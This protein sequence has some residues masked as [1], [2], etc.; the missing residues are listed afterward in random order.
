MYLLMCF[1]FS[2]RRR[3]TR[4]P[5]D[6]SSD[7]CSSDL[8]DDAAGLA[9]AQR[10]GNAVVDDLSLTTPTTFSGDPTTREKLWHVRKGQIGRA[11]CRERVQ[12]S[13]DAVAERQQQTQGKE[14]DEARQA[15]K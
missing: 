7:V 9:E 2:S 13:G 8:A 11:S 10:I 3:H 4:W 12:N 5:R 15:A 6:W 14:K 1:F